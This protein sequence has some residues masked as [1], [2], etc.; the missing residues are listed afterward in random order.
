[1]SIRKNWYISFMQ[2]DSAR[3]I[4]FCLNKTL[5]YYVLAFIFI[6]LLIFSTTAFYV[7]KKN[8]ELTHLSKLE[9]ENEI[10]RERMYHF[11]TQMDSMLIKIKIMEDWEDIIRQERR[12]PVISPDSRALG[13]GGEPFSDPIFLPFCDNLHEL[14][15]EN[16]TKLNYA[17]SKVNLTYQTHFDLLNRIQSRESIYK[18]TPSIWPTFGRITSDFGY[19]IHPIL[20][21]RT[22]HAG[23]DIANEQGTPIYATANGIVSFSGRSG[24][25]GNLVRI[26]HPSGYQT[27]YAHLETIFVGQ[28]ESVFKG[29]IIALMGSSGNSTGFHLHY[30]VM[31]TRRRR[32]VNPTSF[33]NIR[34]EEIITDNNSNISFTF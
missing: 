21:T 23:I 29:Q 25:S 20:R 10:L 30:E 33:F 3:S 28:G 19:R 12:L 14:Y 5:G 2:A 18:S 27:R 32:I 16:I 34:E 4:S 22:L 13:S 8:S 11:T 6:I 1:M 31:D 9:K 15:N 24:A 7:W 26:D 17:F